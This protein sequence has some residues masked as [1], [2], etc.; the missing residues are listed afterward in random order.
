MAHLLSVSVREKKT[1]NQIQNHFEVLGAVP[2]EFLVDLE[3][4]WFSQYFM[5]NQHHLISLTCAL[6]SEFKTVHQ[7]FSVTSSSL[8]TSQSPNFVVSLSSMGIEGIRYGSRLSVD[9]NQKCAPKSKK[10]TTQIYIKNNL[11]D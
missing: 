8:S 10:F 7:L 5:C 3:H 11:S 4:G 9:N 6:E 1:I 2:C